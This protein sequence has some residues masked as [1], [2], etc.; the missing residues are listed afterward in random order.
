MLNVINKIKKFLD[1][2]GWKYR[3]IE[4]DKVFIT[5]VNVGSINGNIKI[6]IFLRTNGYTVYE[7]VNNRAESERYSSISEYL[8]RANYGLN[9]GNFELDYTD[10]EIR[11][12]TYVNCRGI[13][14][15]S[16]EIIEDSI[17]VGVAMIQKY[18]K[19]LL[20][21]MLGVETPSEA[22]KEAENQI[23]NSDE[24]SEN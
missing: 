11:Y 10:G 4:K 1:E 3:Y 21:V 13:E 17:Y 5:G 18:G 23:P 7:I 12:K 20:K 15:I 6:Y 14:E 16:N 24:D 22:I 2:D 9:D 8:H 19:G